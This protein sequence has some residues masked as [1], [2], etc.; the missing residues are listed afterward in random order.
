MNERV[1]ISVVYYIGYNIKK[2]FNE[3]EQYGSIDG[4]FETIDEAMRLYAKITNG[5]RVEAHLLHCPSGKTTLERL[6]VPQS[7]RH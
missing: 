2:W 4:P 3:F 5:G 7:P 1:N 6:E